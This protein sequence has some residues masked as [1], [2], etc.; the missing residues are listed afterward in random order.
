MAE[1]LWAALAVGLGVGPA[2]LAAAG[3]A[4]TGLAGALA[5]RRRT[6]RAADRAAI[7]A[8]AA[9]ERGREYHL[10]ATIEAAERELG[11]LARRLRAHLRDPWDY[12]ASRVAGED[13]FEGCLDRAVLLAARVAE[14]GGAAPAGPAER[15]RMRGQIL[16][17]L[18]AGAAP[19]RR[20]PS[21][22]LRAPSVAAGGRVR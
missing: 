17:G 9:A 21:S 10:P 16:E 3:L 20:P 1:P 6:R 8:G 14:L 15:E 4:A 11:L 5:R 2:P 12:A 22:S 19:P 7:A 18:M 13:A